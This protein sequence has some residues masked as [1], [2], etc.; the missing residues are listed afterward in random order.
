MV[1]VYRE[2][3]LDGAVPDHWATVE[4]DLADESACV[5][6]IAALGPAQEQLTERLVRFMALAGQPP[7][8]GQPS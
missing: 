2:P 7:N 4:A 6:A 5:A 8:P 1:L 3:V